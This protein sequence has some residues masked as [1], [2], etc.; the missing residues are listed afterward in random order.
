MISGDDKA[1]RWDSSNK[2]DS[3]E[4]LSS[5]K[6]KARSQKSKFQVYNVSWK[7]NNSTGVH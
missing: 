4:D 2:P 1:E 5:K 3:L 7:I 6:G